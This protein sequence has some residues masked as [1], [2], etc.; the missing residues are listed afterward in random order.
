M[1]NRLLII[2]FLLLVN[3]AFGIT[4]NLEGT[5]SPDIEWYVRDVR[6]EKYEIHNVNELAGFAALVN[7]TAN[8]PAYN[9]YGK[10][11]VLVDDIDFGS[12]VDDDGCWHAPEWV[13][14]G[15][16][17][18]CHFAGT[19]DGNGHCVKNLVVRGMQSG[20]LFGYN[21]GEIRNL[22]IA[23]G[24]VSCDYYGAGVCS[25]N[26]GVI[27]HCINASNIYCNNYGGGICGK[28]YGNGKLMSCINIGY[29]QDGNFCGGVIGS[30]SPIPLTT[31]ISNCVYDVQMCPLK[32]G[33]GNADSRNAKDLTT[34]QIVQGQGYNAESFVLGDG[35]YPRLPESEL[36]PCMK[37]VLTP[38][39]LP[40]TENVHNVVK[41]ITLPV[42][43]DVVFT[44]PSDSVYLHISG[45]TCKFRK[46]SSVVLRV[47]GGGCTK[48]INI[49][50]NNTTLDFEGTQSRQLRISSFYDLKCFATA[51]N[52]CTHYKGFAN[53]NGFSDVYFVMTDCVAIPNGVNWE[54]VGTVNTPFKGAFNG[55]GC[56]VS[57]LNIMR[58]NQKYCGLFGFCSGRIIKLVTIGGQIV[59]GDYTGG[60]CGYLNSGLLEGCLSTVPVRGHYY[61]GG[62]LG[63]SNMSKL[64]SSIHVNSV[65]GHPEFT[66]GVCGGAIDGSIKLCAFDNKL[67][68]GYPA[69]GQ[70]D[71]TQVLHTYGYRTEAM[72]GSNMQL[73][74]TAYPKDFYWE[75]NLYPMPVST[76]HHAEARVAATPIFID[77]NENVRNLKSYIAFG[78]FDDIS[79]SCDQ[80]D[81]LKINPDLAF[82]LKQGAVILA[83]K[84]GSAKKEVALRIVNKA[85]DPIGSADNPLLIANYS[86]FDKLRNAV[87][88][89]TD[90]KGFAC[91]E[92][93]KG[94][95]FKLANNIRCP[96]GVNQTPIGNNLFPFCGIFDG[97]GKAIINFS[98]GMDNMDNVGVFGYNAGEIRNLRVSLSPI[99]GRYYTGGI[100]GYNAGHIEQCFHDSAS[101]TGTNYTGGICGFDE[102]TVLK[103]TNSGPIKSDYYA[104]GIAGSNIGRVDS[105]INNG[106]V[107]GSSCVG[108]VSGTSS[109]PITFSFNMGRISGNDNIGGISGRNSY[110]L[111]ERCSNNGVVKGADCSGGI[112]GLND[113]TIKQCTNNTFVISNTSGGGIAGRGGKIIACINNGEISNA[114]G[115]SLGGIVGT[116]K[117]NSLITRCINYGN[118]NADSQAGGI[119]SDNLGTITSCVNMGNVNAGYCRGGI[120]AYNSG[121]IKSC[122]SSARVDGE[123]QVGAICAVERDNSDIDKCLYNVDLVT[124]SGIGGDEVKGITYGLSTP[125][126]QNVMAMKNQLIIDDF[127]FEDGKIP[128]PRI[129][130]EKP[131]DTP[132]AEKNDGTTEK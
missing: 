97:D 123:G 132:S 125:L 94:V 4:N 49:K 80:P 66:G 68:I 124:I 88:Y 96:N 119:C 73:L 6:A 5:I 58:P 16:N 76:G 130:D 109:A 115:T 127:V 24:M 84:S 18:S 83:I 75:P 36:T 89:G 28:N 118:L 112:V 23:G 22:V 15:V 82:P 44:S 104:G 7:G 62:V 78:D 13:P 46:R 61:T 40:A 90:Y 93:F 129:M 9:F 100:C 42:V 91:I 53:I 51:V 69:L 45:N 27:D 131:A 41:D 81:V 95:Y 31:V 67:C 87:N 56:V 106:L 64:Q 111:I 103:C 52:N 101:V 10:R 14:I 122:I 79:Y 3:T 39:T 72:T 114:T 126:L 86:D 29:V 17:Y 21:G 92:G 2:A 110:S 8:F 60:I 25:F 105:C 1:M 77:D 85:L 43:D 33:C 20:A 71:G 57:N 120:C 55:Q 121:S 102:G 19:F 116:T 38:I 47:S 99:R 12:Y 35:L 117:A 50:V 26:T 107:S 59:G 98:C 11:V 74:Y 113:G 34:A 65:V 70:I 63:F 54:P 32:K 128:L 48:Y 108:G 37:A 30:N